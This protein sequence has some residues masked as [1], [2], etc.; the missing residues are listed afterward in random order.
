MTVH[1]T[2]FEF[3]ASAMPVLFCLGPDWLK[4]EPKGHL[5]TESIVTHA[6]VTSNVMQTSR[7]NKVLIEAIQELN[8]KN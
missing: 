7:D 4:H 5:A 6:N 1:V 3:R 8:T 2:A